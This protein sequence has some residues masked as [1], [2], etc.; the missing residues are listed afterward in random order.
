MAFVGDLNYTIETSDKPL[1]I[2]CN[3]C[4]Y[5]KVDQE[6]YN[7]CMLRKD[8]TCL[9]TGEC[10]YNFKKRHND[11]TYSL[12]EPKEDM[13]MLIINKKDEYYNSL[14]NVLTKAYEQAAMGKGKERH[15]TADNEHFE[16]QQICEIARRVGTGG[17]A[18][19]AV[20]KIYEALSLP[21]EAAKK[22][23]LGAINYLAAM[24]IVI[25]ETND[26]G[27]TEWID[28]DS[29]INQQGNN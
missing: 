21:K 12:W 15:V 17:P 29:K 18:Y 4:K 27:E 9:F 8:S 16:Y 6:G 26:K 13:S 22:E 23:I 1:S 14:I 10:R 28:I 5:N 25:D 24:Y 7:R 2:S 19:Q 3:T 11:F 20:K